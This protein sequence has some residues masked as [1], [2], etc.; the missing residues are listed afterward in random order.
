MLTS[1]GQL[2]VVPL[3]DEQLFSERILQLANTSANSRLGDAKVTGSLPEM[4]GAAYLGECSEIVD[5]QRGG[6]L[7]VCCKGALTE[8]NIHQELRSCQSL[9][10]ILPA[11]K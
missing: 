4:P 1:R 8:H 3:A 6:Y 10:L 7:F 11:D 2:D 5:V 9:F